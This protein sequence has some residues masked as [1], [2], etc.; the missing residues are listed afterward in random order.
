MKK[1][2]I[3][4]LLL[5]AFLA[6]QTLAAETVF[7]DG[8]WWIKEGFERKYTEPD[9]A[10]SSESWEKV[11]YPLDFKRWND[12]DYKG[13]VTVR[14]SF[15]R[16]S[17]NL[18]KG[19]SLE[20]MGEESS[21]EL[22]IF[23]G[24]IS[25]VSRIYINGHLIGGLGSADPY[26]NGS[27]MNYLEA[28]PDTVLGDSDEV[29]VTFALYRGSDYSL[30]LRDSRLQIGP[31][32]EVISS[33]YYAE[34]LSFALLSIYLAVGLY[35]LLLYTR[36]RKESHNLF[37]GLF[38]VGVTLYWF[39]R[40]GSRDLVFSNHVLIR[41]SL[42]YSILYALG[43]LLV[44]FFSQFL[45]RRYSK[46]GLVYS[47]FATICILITVSAPYPIKNQ[48]LNISNL[49]AVIMLVYILYYVI[50]AA[51]QKNKDA[52]YLLAGFFLFLLGAV[53]DI[54]ATFQVL[55]TPH[56][57]RY[58][59]LVFILGIAGILANRFVRVHNQVEELNQS[60]EKKVEKRTEQLQ[61][62]L[63]EIQT[64]KVQQDGDYYLTS[65]LIKPLG[66][67][68]VESR[69]IDIDILMRQKKQ[70]QFRRWE[71]EIGGD[72]VASHTIELQGKRYAAF[73][74]GDAMGKSIQGAG[75]ALVLGVVFK[76]V[77]SRTQQ[78]SDMQRLSPERWLRICFE[79]LQNVFVSFDGTMMI[80][81]I[82]GL[83]D[84]D[85]GILYFINAEHPWAVLYR[86]QK[87][88]FLEHELQLRKIGI[89][90]LAGKLTV[91]TFAM[92]PGDV[93][94]IGSDGRDDIQIGVDKAGHR[95]INE[96][97]N[98]F[99]RRV[100]DGD[101]Q[102]DRIEEAIL[103]HG[104]L[105]DD[106]TLIRIAYKEDAP[107]QPDPDP[108][109]FQTWQERKARLP[110][111]S[112]QNRETT[113]EI[114]EFLGHIAALPGFPAQKE[115]LKDLAQ[116][117]ARLKDH[118]LAISAYEL[119]VQ[120]FP[121]DTDSLFWLSYHLKRAGDYKRA[122]DVGEQVRLRER[123]TLRYLI[124]LS[125]SHRLNGNMHRARKIL[126]EAANLDPDDEKVQLLQ[127]KI[128]DAG[129]EVPG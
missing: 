63:Q 79:E 40:T 89:E 49:V 56:I 39:M 118:Q 91:Q 104:V 3:S 14:Y 96:D 28:F 52:Y 119:L 102:L 15:P 94:F 83:V 36:R 61:N 29:I 76:A 84:E 123:D 62:S 13:W 97:E 88:T 10:P 80:S 35:H 93:V 53:H 46:I 117:V 90:A 57:T 101:G 105:T 59:F 112:E 21:E 108:E 1:K 34:V 106:F 64:L 30:A 33:Y 107:I 67:N 120:R 41:T 81:A 115:V 75:G 60:L 127:S 45:Y 2:R 5:A 66:G 48:V 78:S 12:T 99:L 69:N 43:P 25:D 42:E 20:V 6:S 98:E 71:A 100:E 23:T 7:L 124:H 72:L 129:A 27:Y 38:C 54:L 74:N 32:G 73:V 37:F 82:L 86:N 109:L 77:I 18:G 111:P 50:R 16:A 65:L 58:A 122:A 17:L 55:N 110:E 92:E 95:I 31:A 4:L 113:R 121:E 24:F 44:L 87:A 51:V 126:N 128:P 114:S 116:T 26:E 8:D 85:T 70:F 125:D 22:A 68:F 103:S 11:A 19:N 47:G 9:F